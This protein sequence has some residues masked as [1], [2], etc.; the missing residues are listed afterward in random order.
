MKVGL[1][2]AA[3][4]K[5]ETDTPQHKDNI[6]EVRLDGATEYTL[7]EVFAKVINTAAG[8]VEAKRMASSIVPNNPQKVPSSPRNISNPIM[9]LDIS[10]ASSI[11]PRIP[12][13]RKL[14]QFANCDTTLICSG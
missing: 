12:S 13:K 3:D 4:K 5:K 14:L 7:S 9:Y 6:I 1:A 10:R 2:K 11:R 8:V